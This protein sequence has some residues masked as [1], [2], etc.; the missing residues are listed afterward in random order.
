[1]D[2]NKVLNMINERDLHCVLNKFCSENLGIKAK[3]IYHEQSAKSKGKSEWL[4][5]DMVGFQL[6][7]S[8]WDTNITNVC[9]DF[10][11][12]KSLL[13]S[14]ELKKSVT[15]DTLREYYFQAVSNSSW[16]NEGYLV[17]ASID[18]SD[19]E[20]MSEIKRL[21]G[22]FGI[23]IIKLDIFNPNNSSILFAAKRKDLV[24][25]ET[26]NKLYS[27]NPNYREYIQDVASSLKINRMIDAS[28]DNIRD[29]DKLLDKINKLKVE[30]NKNIE[31]NRYDIIE[32]NTAKSKEGFAEDICKN[33]D[34]NKITLDLKNQE[35]SYTKPVKC[36]IGDRIY[37]SNDWA[38]LLFNISMDLKEFNPDFFD[39]YKKV[40][41][42]YSESEKSG[43]TYYHK[44][45]DLYAASLSINSKYR[46]LQKLLRIY[47]VDLKKCIIYYKV[48]DTR[49]KKISGRDTFT[50]EVIVFNE[51]E[52][53]LSFTK[54]V[55]CTIDTQVYKDDKWSSLIFNIACDLNKINPMLFKQYVQSSKWCTETK[56]WKDSRYSNE[57]GVYV[58]GLSAS[59]M[60]KEIQKLLD[61]Y[62]IDKSRCSIQYISTSK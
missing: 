35:L 16:S 61:I 10:H 32:N 42:L 20:L 48:D 23:G 49:R 59:D 34:L 50:E 47:N 46:E 22:A 14:F 33:T 24:D 58:G 51:D 1:M 11:V 54:P 27:I 53:D 43:Y 40:S 25:G 18:E 44:G 2:N 4:H 57:L 26:M 30:C 60:Y 45:L 29:Y 12:S 31:H 13:Y 17:A 38:T 36:I 8:N 39:E 28:W 41:R 56:R 3:T 5:P 37:K 6:I 19:L 9:Q 7:T 62:N 15:L 55:K 21:V 52:V